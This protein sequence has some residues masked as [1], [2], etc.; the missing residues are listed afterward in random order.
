MAY[1]RSSGERPTS[2]VTVTT[3]GNRCTVESCALAG[4]ANSARPTATAAPAREAKEGVTSENLGSVT[5]FGE[6]SYPNAHME[7][8]V[9]SWSG[10]K[11][12]ALALDRLRRDPSLN[13]V[14]LLTS[15][16]AVYDRVSIHGVRRAL[17]HAQ[18]R[19]LDLPV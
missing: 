14:V 8:I 12:S 19:A 13:V 3:T 10:G 16:T 15:V 6:S 11:D 1:G 18:A 17:L 7:P 9:L 4:A 2:R 5:E